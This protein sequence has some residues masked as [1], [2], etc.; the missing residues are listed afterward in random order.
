MLDVRKLLLV[1]P[2]LLAEEDKLALKSLIEK[3]FPTDFTNFDM[4]IKNTQAGEDIE[5]LLSD[6]IFND[7]DRVKNENFD[8]TQRVT[9][10]KIESKAIRMM[11][12]DDKDDKYPVQ[13]AIS[14]F[15]K[16]TNLS[17][18]SFQQIKPKEFDEMIGS[19]LYKDGIEI[20]KVP[21]SA[22]HDK[23]LPK[24][25]KQ[26]KA[27]V[28]NLLKE[29][30]IVLSGQHKGNLEEGQIGFGQLEK[31]LKVSLYMNDGKYFYIE[32]GKKTD[33]EFTKISFSDL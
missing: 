19:L 7:L 4:F 27:V 16:K 25:G 32:D 21:S 1:D 20:Y 23:V 6:E 8:H 2:N 31:Y 29:G 11:S 10:H 28:A 17:N 13:R 3:Y 14:I 5:K 22:F 15:D 24:K 30:K 12:N 26:N 18:T 33:K 9:G